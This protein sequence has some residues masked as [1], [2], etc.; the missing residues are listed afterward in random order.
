MKTS[1]PLKYAVHVTR[2]QYS[3]KLVVVEA[4]SKKE[5]DAKAL[6][7]A[8]QESFPAPYEVTHKL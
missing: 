5:A 6:A 4:T 2:V 7:V 3:H 1:K 8:N